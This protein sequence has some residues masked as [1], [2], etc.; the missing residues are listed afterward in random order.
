MFDRV[1]YMLSE[2]WR[3]LRAAPTIT[4]TSIGI[5]ALAFLVFA[6]FLLVV[7]NV[8]SLL[9]RWSA[10]IRVD[11][12]VAD[13]VT[14]QALNSLA[15]RARKLPGVERVE[16]VTRDDAL[17]EF[18]T[19]LG[20]DGSLLDS[21]PKNPLPA[22]LKVYPTAEMRMDVEPL[23]AAL[24][25]LSGVEEVRAGTDWLR[26]LSGVVTLVRLTGLGVGGILFLA[27]ALIISNAIR[28]SVYARRDEIEIMQLVGATNR[29]I[30]APFYLEGA[31]T[32]AGAAMAALLLLRGL[33]AIFLESVTIPIGTLG[34]VGLTFL[35]L[36]VALTFV[37]G[38][39][40]LGL[41]GSAVA[42]GR[43][44]N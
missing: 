35:P 37:A 26:Q 23:A 43:L 12:Y 8:S 40:A 24:R 20:E 33:F 15:E 27:S 3:N 34:G 28:L 14:P 42:L 11:V 1:S 6:T 41:G 32:G 21:L 10:D 2:A 39:I 7:L 44:M 17:S 31:A 9:D 36:S 16:A 5:T 13:D 22:S 38:G 19:A 18:R 25:N 4:L 30:I 29:F